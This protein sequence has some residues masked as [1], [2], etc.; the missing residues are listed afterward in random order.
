[1]VLVPIFLL[2]QNITRRKFAFVPNLS[3]NELWTDEKLYKK[4]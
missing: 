4:I 2:P 1:L 3:M